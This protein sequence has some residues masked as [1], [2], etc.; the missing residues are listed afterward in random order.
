MQIQS[1][2][3]TTPH[4]PGWLQ[5]ERDNVKCWRGCGEAGALTHC[6][7]ECKMVRPITEQSGSSWKPQLPHNLASSLSGRCTKEIKLT[8]QCSQQHYLQWPKSG[9]SPHVYPL[10]SGQ[11]EAGVSHA[12]RRSGTKRQASTD[13]AAT[14]MDPENTSPSERQKTRTAPLH[15]HGTSRRGRSA[16]M[17][18][19]WRVTV[20][21]YTY[22]YFLSRMLKMF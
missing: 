3:D 1:Q 4:P 15:L 18:Q 11:K 16:E 21:I 2:W 9:N 6:W 13:A 14:R 8:R 5:P 20:D 17:E 22:S 7:W 10:T 19:E 12:G